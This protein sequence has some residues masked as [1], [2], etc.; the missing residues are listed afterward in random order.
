M[1]KIRHE[2]GPTAGKDERFGA[3][4]ERITFGRD[5]AACDVVFPANLTIVARRHFALVR[6]PSGDW[7]IELFGE[8]VSPAPAFLLG[9]PTAPP[10]QARQVA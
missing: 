3:G 5:P 1:L 6:R 8:P 4:V 7:T 2:S 10:S 9:L